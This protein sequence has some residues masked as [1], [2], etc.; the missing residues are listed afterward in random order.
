MSE[1]LRSSLKR[2]ADIARKRDENILCQIEDHGNLGM[3]MN[4]MGIHPQ[5]TRKKREKRKI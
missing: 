2:K 3:R 5:M 1:W 4:M